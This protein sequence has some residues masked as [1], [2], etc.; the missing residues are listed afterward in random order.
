MVKSLDEINQE[1]LEGIPETTDVIAPKPASKP[2]V[3]CDQWLLGLFDE[4]KKPVEDSDPDEEFDMMPYSDDTGDTDDAAE[5]PPFLVL[6]EEPE[7]I[8]EETSAEVYIAG[9]P[10]ADVPDQELE[11]LKAEAALRMPESVM[12]EAAAEKQNIK[13]QKGAVG[14]LVADIAFYAVIA[15]ILIATLLYSGKSN[16]G[17]HLF[18]YS[19]FTVLSGSMQREIPKGSLVITRTAEP[20]TIKIGDDIT[21]IR[22]DNVTITHRVV[23]IIENYNNEGQMVFQ[24][25]GLENPE[26]DP[27][28]VYPGNIVGVVKLSIP[29]LGF[30]LNYISENIG[31][32][33]IL[34]GG[35]LVAIIAISKVFSAYRKEDLKLSGAAAS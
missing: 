24:T 1:F 2:I 14:K 26:P 19:G 7:T 35:V 11:A 21:Y 5:L 33:F 31:L 23:D 17:Y 9:F 10:Y 28:Y 15:F 18:G 29:E 27:D 6:D 22:S 8:G 12:A 13:K 4:I 32:V 20:E 16:T 3:D 34:L 25:Q 30:A